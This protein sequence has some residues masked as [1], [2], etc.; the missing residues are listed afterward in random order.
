M[1]FAILNVCVLFPRKMFVLFA[2]E[3]KVVSKLATNPVVIKP[4]KILLFDNFQF[5]C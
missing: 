3:T 5:F 1:H 4:K 2:I